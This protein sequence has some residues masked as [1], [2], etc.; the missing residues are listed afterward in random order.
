MTVSVMTLRSRGSGRIRFSVGLRCV[1]TLIAVHSRVEAQHIALA[2]IQAGM[3]LVLFL[4][5]LWWKCSKRIIPSKTLWRFR[6]SKYA[7]TS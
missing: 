5:L 7:F 4:F 3:L 1:W 2:A 6:C